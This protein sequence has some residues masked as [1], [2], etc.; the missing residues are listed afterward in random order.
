MRVSGPLEKQQ[1]KFVSFAATLALLGYVIYVPLRELMVRFPQP[2]L[3]QS[4]YQA[5]APYVYLVVVALVPVAIAFSVLRY[6]LWDIDLI[7]R[8]TISY[9]ALTTLLAAIYILAV[10]LLQLLVFGWLSRLPDYMLALATLVVALLINPLRIRLQHTIDRRYFR[11]NYDIEK[12][13][14]EFNQA[15]NPLRDPDELRERLVQVVQDTM[16]PET[17]GVWLPAARKKN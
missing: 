5:V 2:E 11:G 9:A 14:A 10:F 4:L 1:T 13:M 12:I 7:I 16:Q 8:R 3:A 6:R 17:L 15:I